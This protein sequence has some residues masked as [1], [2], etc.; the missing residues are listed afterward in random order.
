MPSSWVFIEHA[1]IVQVTKNAILVRWEDGEE[2][3]PKSQ[4]E[5][6][7]RFT[8]GDEGVTVGI[9]EWIAKQKGIE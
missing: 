4:M 2:W 3:F 5:D 7:D 1:E 8:S 9:T 6:P